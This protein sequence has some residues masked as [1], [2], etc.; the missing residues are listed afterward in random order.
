[1]DGIIVVNKEKGYTSHDIVA[2]I[3]KELQ[4][5]K[6]GHTGTLDPNATGVLPILLG[7]GTKLSQYLTDHDKEYE[8]ILELGTQT[9]TGDAEGKVI[10]QDLNIKE[11]DKKKI[12][13]VL[14]S[15]I[16]EMEQLPPMYSAIK[17]KGKKLY[18]Y[19]REGK[20]VEI[21]VRKIKIYNIQLLEYS[22]N[23]IKFHVSCSKGTYIRTLCEE[24]AN[25]LGTI[26]YMK[27]L[28][29]TKVG[30]F[31]LQ[32]S[33]KIGEIGIKNSQMHIISLQEFFKNKDNIYLTQ[34]QLKP[35]YNGV[36]ITINNMQHKFTQS[37]QN[38]NIVNVYYNQTW[39]GIAKFLK[40]ESIN[41]IKRE[42][43]IKSIDEIC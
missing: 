8:A 30:K 26:G 1:M 6:V 3:R 27:E 38:D 35:F 11:F 40:E 10:N 41:K 4:I 32:D 7:E 15:C 21:P 31:T 16:G 28:K 5:K 17:V 13:Q 43:I 18:E 9:D 24:I 34:R 2:I 33:I 37:S 14:Q 36:K 23:L 25:R 19:A 20:K 12:L 22:K 39:L 42:I 29:R